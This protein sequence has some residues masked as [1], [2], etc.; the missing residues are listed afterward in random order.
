MRIIAVCH[1]WLQLFMLKR[2]LRKA[3]PGDEIAGF[4]KQERALG[5]AMC[6]VVD[7]VFVD[8]SCR[9]PVRSFVERLQ[10]LNPC[11]NLI[12]IAEKADGYYMASAFKL[13]A[14][15][16]IIKPYGVKEIEAE[17]KNLRYTGRDP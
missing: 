16:Y 17:L 7:A 8:I 15:G 14:S 4:T 9:K 6:K 5:H 2:K 11:I 1:D 12:F 10:E 13:H 3:A